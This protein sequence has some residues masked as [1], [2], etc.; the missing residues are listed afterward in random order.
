MADESAVQ[1]Q[2]EAAVSTTSGC[3]GDGACVGFAVQHSTAQLGLAGRV[4]AA[5]M[6]SRMP[7][8]KVKPPRRIIM[9]PFAILASEKL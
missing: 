4:T 3:E 8:R 9:N 7:P 5:R 2:Q 1:L 6:K